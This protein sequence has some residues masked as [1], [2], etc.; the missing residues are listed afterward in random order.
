MA[1]YEQNLQQQI[2]LCV[3][4]YNGK[5]DAEA[6]FNTKPKSYTIQAQ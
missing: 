3:T 6:T 1:R 2:I 4:V 5:A